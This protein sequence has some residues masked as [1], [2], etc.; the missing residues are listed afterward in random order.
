MAS[1]VLNQNILNNQA[2]PSLDQAK[3]YLNQVRSKCNSLSIPT[4][5]LYRNYLKNIANSLL[6]IEIDINASKTKIDDTL[7][8][9]NGVESK[10]SNKVR[11]LT[12]MVG[13]V[14]A[15]I[16]ATV[17]SNT[18]DSVKEKVNDLGKTAA[19]VGKTI[20]G[21]AK[22]AWGWAADKVSDI[23]KTAAKV[24]DAIANWEK[25]TRNWVTDKVNDIKNTAAK[26]GK[27]V[28]SWCKGAWNWISNVAA[29][30]VWD[31][32]KKTGSLIA[33]AVQ[34]IV[35]GLLEVVEAAVD[36]VALV[37]TG[38]AS[39]FT[40]IWDGGQAIYGAITGNEWHS[41]TKAMWKGTKS[42]VSTTWVRNGYN[43][44]SNTA[45]GKWL[46]ENSFGD[47]ARTDGM[48][49]Q[50]AE[51]IGYA[52]GVVALSVVTFGTA[53]PLVLATT[54]G[55]LAVSKYTEEAWNNNK[56]SIDTGNGNYD[57]SLNYDELSTLNNKGKLKKQIE[58]TDELGN[59]ITTEVTFVKNE[60]GSYSAIING[61][62][63]ICNVDET[64]IL[65]G[66]S[67]GAMNGAWEFGQWYL[68]GQIGSGQFK[69]L[70]GGIKSA[71]M[72]KLA[73]SGTRVV[74]DSVTGA[75][76]TPFR[77]LLDTMYNDMTWEEAWNKN[78]GWNGVLSQTLIAGIMSAGGEVLD[79]RKYFKDSQTTSN[80]NISE[81]E[82]KKMFDYD[83]SQPTVDL[84]TKEQIVNMDTV[85]LNRVQKLAKRFNN[86][87][88]FVAAYKNS[89]ESWC[90]TLK[91]RE[92]KLIYNYIG[93]SNYSSYATINS[94]MRDMSINKDAKTINLYHT[95][96]L[97]TYTFDEYFNEFGETVDQFISRTYDEAISLN[98]V[99]SRTTFAEDTI[100]ARGVD[101]NALGRFGITVADSPDDI[102]RKL[103][104]IYTDK[105]FMSCTPVAGGGFTYKDVNFVMTCKKGMAF[106]DF[107]RFNAGE[108]EILLGLG[109]KFCIES[110][111]KIENKIMIYMTSIN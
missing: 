13:N 42:F 47:W 53:T 111:E 91:D 95:W 14:T 88:E 27:T 43:A 23:K 30:A 85:E 65:E 78:G 33:V 71:A 28:S 7:A 62:K 98:N 74:L 36:L 77:T 83:G 50:V 16:G 67:Y 90:S 96:G 73:V 31:V 64:G 38:V 94:V 37:R 5:F 11:S 107:S 75:V 110:V 84:F 52:A 39:I 68:G 24:G 72:Q 80:I 79:L 101:M 26:V 49:S 89:T 44:L 87:E 102:M 54:A 10:T 57:M 46:N 106:G 63:L 69:C 97:K 99:I 58:Q 86:Y 48:V 17:V 61:Q 51:G 81:V 76:E 93:E 92:L 105:G 21:W 3:R 108:K 15:N 41:A 18:P 6:N 34:S 9:Y 55:S 2:K 66:L 32:L 1:L 60:D 109:S 25:D 104:S 100:V 59:V 56:I 4:S 22:G 103:G 82:T 70:T 45:Y 19:K 40:G 8:Q 35:A 29:P 12:A 20:A